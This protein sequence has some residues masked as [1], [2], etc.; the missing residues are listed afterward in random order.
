MLLDRRRPIFEYT[1]AFM[2]SIAAANKEA[3]EGL[4]GGLPKPVQYLSRN[5]N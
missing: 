5:F 3:D 1:I 2:S 4:V